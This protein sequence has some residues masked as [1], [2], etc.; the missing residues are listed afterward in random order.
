M[1]A[2][3]RPSLRR[4][5]V[6]AALP[7]CSAALVRSLAAAALAA[8]TTGCLVLAPPDYEH[9]EQTAP[10][11]S[12]VFPPPHLP[13]HIN[14]RDIVNFSVTVLSEDNGDPVQTALYIDYGKRSRFGMPYRRGEVSPK[15]IA[16]G[17]IAGGQRAITVELDL[18]TMTIPTEGVTP[19]KECHT[20]TVTASH[21]F[22]GCRCPTDPEDMSSLTW[23]LIHCDPNDPACPASCPVLDCKTTPCLF[24]DDPSLQD[25][26]VDANP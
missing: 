6:L 26:C 11:L 13:I 9:P 23:Q 2:P 7:R 20:L 8:S 21:A 25:G 5:P 4:A 1:I 14:E 15:S 10:V 22:N 16:A 17:T 19:E 24:C 3:S 18:D 12:A